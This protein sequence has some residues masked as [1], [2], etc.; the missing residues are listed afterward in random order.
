MHHAMTLDINIQI[1]KR[2]NGENLEHIE[3][4]I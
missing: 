2:T 3:T 1:I 4:F